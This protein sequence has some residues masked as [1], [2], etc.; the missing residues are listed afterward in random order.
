MSE[1]SFFGCFMQIPNLLIENYTDILKNANEKIV[2]LQKIKILIV[3][4]ETITTKTGYIFPIVDVYYVSSLDSIPSEEK[5]KIEKAIES[6]KEAN[7][8]EIV[9]IL[10][11]MREGKILRKRFVCQNIPEEEIDNI[12]DMERGLEKEKEKHS[13]LKFESI[14]EKT[15]NQYWSKFLNCIENFGFN[16]SEDLEISYNLEKIFTNDRIISKVFQENYK[17]Y[18]P[19]KNIPVLEKRIPYIK[20]ERFSAFFEDNRILKNI[21]ESIENYEVRHGDIID[22]T[23]D[24]KLYQ[25]FNKLMDIFIDTL[26]DNLNKIY[27][28]TEETHNF[29]S[30][31]ITGDI[32]LDIESREDGYYYVENMFKIEKSLVKELVPNAK[33]IKYIIQVNVLKEYIASEHRSFTFS[34][35][36]IF[37]VDQ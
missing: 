22:I 19:S 7:E 29:W 10:L 31:I 36:H 5:E 27:I 32:V 23:E 30:L 37:K 21:Y 15:K 6:A 13:K 18:F 12:K 16:I 11:C 34:Q 8:H 14:D 28:H 26:I 9:K 33:K 1:R 4:C 35:N 2:P 24:L 25:N 3:D 17:Y 20:D